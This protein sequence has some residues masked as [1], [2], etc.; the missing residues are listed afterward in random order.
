MGGDLGIGE[1]LFWLLCEQDDRRAALDLLGLLDDPSTGLEAQATVAHLHRSIGALDD[2]VRRRVFET[3]SALLRA[4]LDAPRRM[5]V[6]GGLAVYGR[7]GRRCRQCGD[8]V[9]R[10]R[11]GAPARTT[12]FCPT[13]QPSLVTTSPVQSRVSRGEGQR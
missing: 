7:A 10:L 12:Y 4:N 11:Q 9:R 8:R 2:A 6:P 3:A 1:Q 5:T 13:C